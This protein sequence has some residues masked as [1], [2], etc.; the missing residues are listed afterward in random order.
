[1]LLHRPVPRTRVRL[2]RTLG[3]RAAWQATTHGFVCFRSRDTATGRFRVWEQWHLRDADDVDHRLT[4]VHDDPTRTVTL[5]SP[6]DV[7]E[8]L[9]PAALRV[10]EELTVTLDGRPHRLQ[11][12]RADAAEVLHVLGDPHRDVTVG[13]RVAHAELRAPGLVVTVQDAGGGVLDVHRGTVLDPH[14]Q[15]R[16]LGRD[17]RPRTNRFLVACAAFAGVVLLYNV[18]QACLPDSGTTDVTGAVGAVVAPV[19]PAVVTP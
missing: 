14:A 5:S 18:L 17:V 19:G 9:D 16:V 15:R 6:V 10:G 12:V 3:R 2:G 11:V 7:P 8:R 1:M 13:D 4:Y